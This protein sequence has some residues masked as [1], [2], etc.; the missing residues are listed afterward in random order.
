MRKN[1]FFILASFVILFALVYASN[2]SARKLTY[3]ERKFYAKNNIIFTNPCTTE[4]DCDSSSPGSGS[5]GDDQDEPTT[6][7]EGIDIS[8]TVFKPCPSD[9]VQSS[10]H[11]GSTYSYSHSGVT[12]DVANTAL[13]LD[14][15]I[16]YLSRRHIAQD[17]KTCDPTSSKCYSEGE[18]SDWGHCLHFATVHAG[19]LSRGE[20]TSTDYGAG[21]YAGAISQSNPTKN[22]DESNKLLTLQAI[23]DGVKRGKPVVV[24]VASGNSRHFVTAVGVRAG[25]NR[26]SLVETDMLYL[27]TNGR[28]NN[29]RK[30]FYQA[31]KGG[32]WIKVAD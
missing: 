26:S 6:G 28:L 13:D 4:S 29:T 10:T 23:Y 25:A 3:Q 16:S 14:S 9:M 5:D 30:L 17:G 1:T 31:G 18:Y 20:C 32:Y 21:H 19:N 27:D 2:A 24:K 8:M 12:Y 15:Y 22:E 11:S 7:P